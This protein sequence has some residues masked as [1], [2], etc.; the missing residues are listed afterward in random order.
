[1]RGSI[2]ATCVIVSCDKGA[3]KGEKWTGFMK[4][5]KRFAYRSTRSHHYNCTFH[6]RAVQ[7]PDSE[8]NFLPCGLHSLRPFLG[9]PRGF[10]L[11]FHSILEHRLDP[12]HWGNTNFLSFHLFYNYGQNYNHSN[13]HRFC[14]LLWFRH[15]PFCKPHVYPQQQN[16][17]KVVPFGYPDYLAMTMP[18]ELH[19]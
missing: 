10:H 3:L 8:N 5:Y 15:C 2:L 19:Y 14:T 11:D 12:I 6:I 16:L 18:Y 4:P 17:D 1:M 7:Y 13:G 9:Y